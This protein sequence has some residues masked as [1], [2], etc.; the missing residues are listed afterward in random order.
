MR[1]RCHDC[2]SFVKDKLF[3]GLL[4][5]YTTGEVI[6]QREMNRRALQWDHSLAKPKPLKPIPVVPVVD[7]DRP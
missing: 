4:H 5:A 3:F 6:T 7:V 1:Y 2:G